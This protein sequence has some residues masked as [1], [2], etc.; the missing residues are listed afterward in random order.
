MPSLSCTLGLRALLWRSVSYDTWSALERAWHG[1]SACCCWSWSSLSPGSKLHRQIA[2]I[3]KFRRRNW[4]VV[5][6]VELPCKP[7]F[8]DP[9]SVEWDSWTF[10]LSVTPVLRALFCTPW[11]W[12][13]RRAGHRSCPRGAH[14]WVSCA[15]TDPCVHLPLRVGSSGPSLGFVCLTPRTDQLRLPCSAVPVPS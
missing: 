5:V 13:R 9:S 1:G 12:W 8:A 6:R 15:S 3:P 2:G 14:G 11:A 10:A 7:R 4:G